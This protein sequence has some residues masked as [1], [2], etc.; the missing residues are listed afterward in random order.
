MR[1]NSDPAHDLFTIERI[2]NAPP[3]MVW[4]AYTTPQYVSRWWG[5]Q[6]FT[7][8]FCKIDFR[9]GGRF[10]YCMKSPDGTEYWNVGEFKEIVP[11]QKI[12]SVMY[13]SD[14]DGNK[15]DPSGK[16]FADDFA[17][18][19]PDVVTFEP[20]AG[21]KTKLTLTTNHTVES[22]KKYGMDEGM[23]QTLD[24]F[25]AVLMSKGQER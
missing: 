3:E 24:K 15:V 23:K 2:F 20:V 19:A 4:E 21:G 6:G 8:P 12:V 14:K 22:A 11:L 10:H 13:M 17:E 16:G 5:P 25:E 1:K 18:E 7:A 9:V